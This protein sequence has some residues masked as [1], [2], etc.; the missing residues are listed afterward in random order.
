L[1]EVL[2]SEKSVVDLDASLRQRGTT[3]R[4][5]AREIPVVFGQWFSSVV[6]GTK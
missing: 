1:E 6:T 4:C 3:L 5:V 2:E